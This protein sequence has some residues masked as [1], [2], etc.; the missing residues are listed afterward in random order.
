[1]DNSITIAS[2]KNELIG[3]ILQ[4][5]DEGMLQQ[6]KQYIS[7][8]KRRNK[9]EKKVLTQQPPQNIPPDLKMYIKP[10]PTTTDFDTIT[11]QQN[12]KTIDRIAFDK[13]VDE[14]NIQEPLADLI[15][16]I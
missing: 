12:F 7:D 3:E 2:L 10:L 4:L 1:M 8:K 13:A 9:T 5:R 15:K 14:L 6:I 16:M 11:R